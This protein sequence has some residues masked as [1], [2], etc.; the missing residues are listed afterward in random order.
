[1]A[2]FHG[3]VPARE[4]ETAVARLVPQSPESFTGPLSR[5]AWCTVASGYVVRG[6]DRALAPARQEDTAVRT[7]G[8]V[9]RLPSRHSPFLFVP[10]ACA[11][12]FARIALEATA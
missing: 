7:A 6:R 4:A 9:H 12:L 11:S 1:M 10:A 3:D 5:A 2:T 8:P